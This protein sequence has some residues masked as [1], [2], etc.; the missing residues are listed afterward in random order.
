M[1][2]VV[3]MLKD[4]IRRTEA[5]LSNWRTELHKR[6]EASNEAQ[7]MVEMLVAQLE[8]LQDQLQDKDGNERT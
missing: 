2:A 3:K 7:T 6:V 8:L 5:D 4:N 1:S